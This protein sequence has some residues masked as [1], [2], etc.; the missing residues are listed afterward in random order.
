M[1]IHCFEITKIMINSD[2]FQI[3]TITVS[4]PRLIQIQ[5]KKKNE[6][7]LIMF[8]V[9]PIQDISFLSRTLGFLRS[10]ITESYL[11]TPALHFL[12]E[13]LSHIRSSVMS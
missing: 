3:Q 2:K 1:I 10:S 6:R 7:S 9:N 5:Y 12:M 13:S 11:S 8:Q 4:I